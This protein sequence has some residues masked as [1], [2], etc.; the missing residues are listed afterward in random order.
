MTSKRRPESGWLSEH[1]ISVEFDQEAN[2]HLAPDQIAQQ[3]SKKVW[4]RCSVN[5]AHRWQATPN[6]RIGKGSGCPDCSGTRVSD[7]NRL[8]M[9]CPDEALLRQWDYAKNAPL[10]PNDVSVSSSRKVWWACEKAEDHQWA[11][12]VGKR[13]AGRGCPYCSGTRVSSSNRLST[14]RPDIAGQLNA[15]LSGISADDLSVGSNR[16]VWWNC[17]IDPRHEPWTAPVIRRTG[18]H[19]RKGAGCPS[20]QLVHTSAQELRLKAELSTVLPIDPDRI[21]VRSATGRLEKVDM[22]A[23]D[24]TRD[25]RLVLEFDGVWWHDSQT[26]RQRDMD[27]ARRLR[28]AGW[29]VVRIREHHLEKLDAKFDV[30]VGFNA[31]EDDATLTVLDHLVSL[32][33]VTAAEVDNYRAAGGPRASGQAEEWIR[34][35]LG[36]RALGEDRRSHAEAWSRMH[37]ALLAFEAESG[38]CR[39]PA[40]VRIEGVD[41]ARWVHKQRTTYRKGKMAPERVKKLLEIR[42]WS[43]ESPHEAEFWDGYRRY[44]AWIERREHTA[45]TASE[46]LDSRAA[47]IWASNLRKR[48]QRLQGRREDLPPDQLK[49]M[50]NVPG[51][52]WDP[53]EDEFQEKFTILQEFV[54][55]TGC[56]TADIKQ[57]DRWRGHRIGSWI[58]T[59][60]TRRDQLPPERQLLLEMLPGWTWAKHEDAWE[61][62]FAELEKFAAVHGHT[63]PSLTAASEDERALARWKRNNKNRLQGKDDEKAQRLR[64]LLA[65]YNEQLP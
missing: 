32:G 7:A 58:N 17:P 57:R 47:T 12:S 42:S 59:W 37:A 48:R 55:E 29:T 20:C 27:K 46:Q 49:A 63:K 45:E 26:R 30:I 10:T 41:L 21:C 56:T 53:F 18:G 64:R 31:D 8:S 61:S 19:K 15:D 6:N 33:I 16:A 43:F 11:A 3:S 38:H 60:R 1:P 35:K 22:V 36:E 13:T 23:E 44:V 34:D 65:R 40:D 2:A 62:K 52:R 50:A 28:E 51:W 54:A 25:L 39:V 4:W 5:S 9:N 24:P 14:K